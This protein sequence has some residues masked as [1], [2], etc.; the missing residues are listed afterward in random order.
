MPISQEVARNPGGRGFTD[1]IKK[2][3]WTLT[4]K[5]G[6]FVEIDKEELY[7][8][9]TYQRSRWSQTKINRYAAAWSWVKCGTLTVA[10][11]ENQ[12]F[13]IDGATRKQAADK[14][15]DI[16][17]LPC[18][19]YDLDDSV[20]SEALGFVGIN[21][22]K[23]A[24][25]VFDRFKA[26]LIGGDKCAIGLNALITSTGHKAS[27]H[28]GIK[29]VSCLMTIWKLY[30]RDAELLAELWPTIADVNQECQ[31]KDMFVRGMFWAEMQAR[32]HGMSLLRNPY[33]TML[34][35]KT[36]EYFN[37]EIRR[38]I[39][40]IGKGGARIEANAIIKALNKAKSK[41]AKKLPILE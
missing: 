39:I 29:N 22:E 34:I 3:G 17:T 14:R 38:E 27:P 7:V 2:F 19:V 25:E 32:K 13:V 37:A 35:T 11:R 28:G 40:I 41:T 31:I 21:S 33:K 1:K 10:I 20:K 15:S 24:V 18:M 5:P 6:E 16:R 9:P 36:G 12:W 26:M 8:D 30:K 4:D 23:T